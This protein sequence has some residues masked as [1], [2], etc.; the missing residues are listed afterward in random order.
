MKTM[1]PPDNHVARMLN[2]LANFQFEVQHRAATKHGN[3]DA[4]SRAPH[5]A[6]SAS[7][8][9]M[10]GTDDKIDNITPGLAA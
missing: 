3:A 8:T 7:A 9:E 10:I 6:A 2:F 1:E 5:V 4:L